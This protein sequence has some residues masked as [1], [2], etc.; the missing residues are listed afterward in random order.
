[1]RI[2]IC[3]DERKFILDLKNI[4]DKLYN[5]LDMVID[6]F[7]D[8]SELLRRFNDRK[9]DIVFLDIE[10]PAI[11][12]LTLA[13]KLRELSESV[14]IVFLTGH[15]EYAVKGYEVN[16]LRYLTKP[17]DE[18][19]VR[20]VL[21]HVMK[22]QSGEKAM[23]VKYAEGEHKIRLNDMLY[24][25]AQNQKVVI[26]TTEGEIE[27]RGKLSDYEEKLLN[28]G[29]FRIHR[30]YLVSLSK[31]RG[32]SGHDI[33]MQ[34]GDLLPVGRTKMQSFKSALMAYVDTEAF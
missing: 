16:A 2:A 19:A 13:R 21:D 20:E 1:M 29:F 23:W 33:T 7:S 34:N 14:Y 25:E 24:I 30:G 4:I 9:Y 15:I 10:M 8:G 18:A 17:A 12:G 27:V 32:I 22:K 6:E 11:D 31:V 26:Y 28:E 5:S 3:D